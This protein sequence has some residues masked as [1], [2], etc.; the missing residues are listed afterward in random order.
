MIEKLD[1]LIYGSDAIAVVTTLTQT[2]KIMQIVSIVLTIL[3]TAVSLALSIWKWWKLAKKDGEITAEEI[4]E[5]QGIIDEH[6]KK[7]E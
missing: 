7:G 6:T 4:D 2:D 5:L 3:A 1:A